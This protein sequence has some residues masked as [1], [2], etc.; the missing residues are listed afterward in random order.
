MIKVINEKLTANIMLRAFQVV[1]SGKESAKQEM[2]VQ[3]LGWESTEERNGNPLQYPCLGNTMHRGISV[4][5]FLAGY[6]P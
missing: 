1:A 5:G 4:R 2:Q 6:S 3:Y